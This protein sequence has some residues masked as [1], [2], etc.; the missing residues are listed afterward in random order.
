MQHT[1]TAAP[2]WAS[3]LSA[4]TSPTRADPGS[5]MGIL[6]SPPGVGKTSLFATHPSCFHLNLDITSIPHHAP[7]MQSWPTVNEAGRPTGSDGKPIVLTWDGVLERVGT[8]LQMAETNQPRPQTILIDSM[9][10]AMR[11]LREHCIT[12]ANRLNL[13]SG[14]VNA[15]K[16]LDGRA[17]WDFVYEEIVNVT[18]RLK[19]AGYGVWWTLHLM[20]ETITNDDGTAQRRMSLN[21]TDNF[22][23][24]LHDMME[25][26]MFID[27]TSVTIKET[28]DEH[29]MIRGK[30]DTSKVVKVPVAE[31]DKPVYRLHFHKASL[32]GYIKTRA[33]LPPSIELE[34]LPLTFEEDGK[35]PAL[36]TPGDGWGTF[37]EA[38]ADAMKKLAAGP[39]QR[40]TDE[41]APG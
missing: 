17:A 29:P 14:P 15:W 23:K 34:S 1:T 16:D 39:Q 30:L 21:I 35:T 22:W 32:S 24:R 12:H 4:S 19:H 9:A 3:R 28:R 7:T 27:R 2:T 20:P 40:K 13:K 25:I 37:S 41:P 36:W 6:L 18:Q 26:V 11:L 31:Y 33:P 38:Y 8:L 10:A 5:V